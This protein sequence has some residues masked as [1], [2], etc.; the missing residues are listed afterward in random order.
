MKYKLKEHVTSEMLESV[1]FR[2]DEAD[3][4][5]HFYACAIK[6]DNIYIPLEECEF[7]NRIIQYYASGTLPEELSPE[8][9]KD[10]IEKGWV[11]E[12]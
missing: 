10:L 4:Y 5:Y 8:D 11:E 2:V 1:G 9:I 7:G 3:L 6:D 12:V